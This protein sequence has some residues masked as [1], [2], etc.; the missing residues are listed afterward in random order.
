MYREKCATTVVFVKTQFRSDAR[1]RN[2]YAGKAD[3]KSNLTPGLGLWG[4]KLTDPHFLRTPS[5]M[6]N[7][8][9]PPETRVTAAAAAVCFL[10]R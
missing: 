7:I 6:N 4:N 1:R 10:P 3:D 2:A 5:A 9:K 8:E